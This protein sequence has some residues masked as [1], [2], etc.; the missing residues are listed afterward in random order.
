MIAFKVYY[1]VKDLK[2][3]GKD[4]KVYYLDVSFSIVVTVFSV[5]II[6]AYSILLHKFMALI[7]RNNGFLDFMRV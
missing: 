7:K 1:V 2:N 4:E 5:V 3:S 6:I